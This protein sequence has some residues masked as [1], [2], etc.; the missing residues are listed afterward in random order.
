LPVG[1]ESVGNAFAK[2]AGDG[3][4]G[5]RTMVDSGIG[6]EEFV[7]LVGDRDHDPPLDE[8]ALLI[9]S[10]GTGIDV[11]SWLHRLDDLAGEALAAAAVPDPAGLAQVLFVD[12]GFVGDTV[13]YGDPRNSF[14]SEVIDRRR[15]MPITLSV[16]MIEVGRRIGLHL[17]PVGMPGHFIVGSGGEQFFD[18]FHAGVRLDRAGA[19]A[20]FRD[21]HGPAVPFHD[22]YLAPISNRMVLL[23]ILTNLSQSYQARR[24]AALRWVA[25]LQLAFPELPAAAR[26]DIGEALASVGAFGDAAAVFDRLASDATGTTAD[27]LRGRAQALRAR[28]N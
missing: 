27:D 21:Q 2:F 22:H 12:W 28:S 13:D 24:S 10:I 1:P 23:R 4:S 18:P 8:G 17:D 5:H 6:T 19:I 15:G 11:E 16:L 9:A 14:L 3:S 7:A 26:A 25:R 20:R